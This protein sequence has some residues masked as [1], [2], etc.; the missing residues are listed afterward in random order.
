MNRRVTITYDFYTWKRRV[1]V[2]DTLVIGTKREGNPPPLKLPIPESI[3]TARV[4]F[5]DSCDRS[6]HD[7]FLHAQR[8]FRASLP[9][10]V[11]HQVLLPAA[12]DDPHPYWIT[13]E[14]MPCEEIE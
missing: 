12:P 5:V 1:P 14:D 8:M 7:C 13:R 2:A 3:G 11:C 10:G 9:R 6:A 4:V